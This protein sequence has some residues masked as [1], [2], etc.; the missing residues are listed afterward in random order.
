V[1]KEL[2]RIKKKLSINR[3]LSDSFVFQG[4]RI[5]GL[6]NFVW[7]DSDSRGATTRYFGL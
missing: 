6:R 3:E 4:Y 5:S 1:T 2:I 7:S